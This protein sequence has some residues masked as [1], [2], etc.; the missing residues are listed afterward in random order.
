MT[1]ENQQAEGTEIKVTQQRIDELLKRVSITG[2][3]IEGT[4]VTVLTAFLDQ[5]FILACEYSACVDINNFNPETGFQIARAKLDRAVVQKL[6][7]LEGYR[8]YMETFGNLH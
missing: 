4:S 6:W 3:Q 2:G 8:L 1:E 5:Q 7:E